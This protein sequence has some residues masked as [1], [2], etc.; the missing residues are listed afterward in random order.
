GVR[1]GARFDG[2]A[3]L[4]ET[5]RELQ[6]SASGFHQ[7]RLL[8][9]EAATE[10]AVRGDVLGAYRHL[11]FATHGLLREDLQGL[12]DPALVLTPVSASDP[13]D[14][15][16]LTASEIADLNLQASFVAL[17][18]CNT[19]NFDFDQIAQDLPALASAFAVSGVPA[20]LG[21]LWPVDSRTGEA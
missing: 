4:P 15:G 6:A 16:L 14:D 2:L 18:A 11:S 12:A 8:L 3:P 17:S 1:A 5:R 9:G 20:T 7:P 21:T 13:G 19:A 10:R